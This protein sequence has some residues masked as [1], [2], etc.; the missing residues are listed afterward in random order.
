MRVI[1]LFGGPGTGKSTTAAD[2]FALMKWNNINVE[3]VDEFAKEISWE[4][5]YTILDDQYYITAKQ[6]RKLW[7]LQEQVDWAISDSP[8]IMSLCY[9]D[10]DYFPTTFPHFVHDLYNH[11]HNVNVFLVREK[12]FHPV[13]RH[14]NE[15]QSVALDAEIK[16]MLD[17]MNYDYIEVPAN[18]NAKH[19]I[20]EHI[21]GL[22]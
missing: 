4:K 21:R 22:E 7:R 20:L 16:Y 17:D 3:L 18:E 2:L 5:R 14:H 11:Y 15:Q 10:P 19:V 8:L 9:A 12:P 6:N 1:N 13:G